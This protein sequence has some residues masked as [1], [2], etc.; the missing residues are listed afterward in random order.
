MQKTN[1]S[2]ERKFCD[3]TKKLQPNLEKVIQTLESA[4]KRKY[5][6]KKL[7]SAKPERKIIDISIE[8]D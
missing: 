7:P 6:A 8:I 1:F 3:K 2:N 4:L 5:C